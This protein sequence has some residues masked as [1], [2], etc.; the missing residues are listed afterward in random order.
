MSFWARKW[1][2]AKSRILSWDCK[3]LTMTLKC[4]SWESL[5]NNSLLKIMLSERA[6]TAPRSKINLETFLRMSTSKSKIKLKRKKFK[7]DKW[8]SVS[9]LL[10][11]KMMNWFIKKK[12]KMSWKI[13]LSHSKSRLGKNRLLLMIFKIGLTCCSLN[14]SLSTGSWPKSI[15]KLITWNTKS[16]T[17]FPP[18][19]KALAVVWIISWWTLTR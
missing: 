2:E 10:K 3:T 7:L 15:R 17:W 16:K 1:R 12:T 18:N 13:S 11:R 5:L 8:N 4:R 19:Q 14:L 6:Q 9:L